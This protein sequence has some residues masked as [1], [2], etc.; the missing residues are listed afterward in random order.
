MV[1]F[2][3][4]VN[5]MWSNIGNWQFGA[6][7][8]STKNAT[9]PTG[10]TNFATLTL[11]IVQFNNLSLGSEAKLIIDYTTLII[12]GTITNC[13]GSINAI[14]GAIDFNGV[15][16]Q[17]IPAIVFTSNTVRNE[18]ISNAAGVSQQVC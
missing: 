15:V 2:L 9:A 4:A 11:R 5:T 13:G 7:P 17:T 6:I 14:T 10:L 12:S 3:N 18:I 16:V 8:I 1:R